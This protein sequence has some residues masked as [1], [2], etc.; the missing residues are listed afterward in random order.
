MGDPP[1]DRHPHPE[2]MRSAVSS[3][4]TARIWYLHSMR[5]DATKTQATR[6]RTDAQRC[7][8]RDPEMSGEKK[9]EQSTVDQND[10]FKTSERTVDIVN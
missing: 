5:R 2:K 8:P 4:E 6:R 1:A 7:A 9:N 3:K 10:M